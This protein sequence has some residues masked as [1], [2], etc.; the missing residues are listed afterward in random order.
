[1]PE[2]DSRILID[3]F[4]SNNCD[5]AEAERVAGFLENNIDALDSI[6]LT[7]DLTASEI[8]K[9]PYLEKTQLADS[10]INTGKERVISF[11][12]LLVA[13]SVIGLIALAWWYFNKTHNTIS[14]QKQVILAEN[15]VRNN[16]PGSMKYFL[17]DS[18]EIIMLPG[19]EITFQTEFKK[20]RSVQL[21]EGDIFFSVRHNAEYPFAVTANGI[22][23]TALGTRFWVRNFALIN[24][25]SIA[26]TEGKILINSV[27]ESFSMDSVLLKPGQVCSIDKKTG[28]IDIS[29]N[30][31][32][33]K[34]KARTL[35]ITGTERKLLP[36]NKIVWTNEDMQFSNVRL[37]NVFKRL[38]DRYDVKII[39]EDPG[40]MDAY[41]TGKIFYSDSLNVIIRSICELNRLSYEKRN[42]T[43][44]LKRK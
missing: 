21:I 15:R 34:E 37:A 29:D 18:S 12:K 28:T 33:V 30:S 42:D 31:S 22:K 38:E 1:M 41:L 2:T 44:F 25:L 10:I 24:A 3:K 35:I 40:I 27:E 14:K 4:L 17:P 32:K 19:S 11:R 39:A 7:E 8:I 9:T 13:A 16:T 5:Y 26:L 6:A 23:T 43:I 36:A 20:N